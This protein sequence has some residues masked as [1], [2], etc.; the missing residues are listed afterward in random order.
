[1]NL[2]EAKAAHESGEYD[3]ALEIFVPM[4][5][6]GDAVAQACLG[7]MYRFG[8]GVEE[9]AAEA[10]KWFR[11]AAE[12]GHDMA[13]NS[14]GLMYLDGEGVKKN[15]AEGMQWLRRAAEQCQDWNALTFTQLRLA[16]MYR[17]GDG[18]QQDGAEAVKWLRKAAKLG[19]GCA[20]YDLGRMYLDGEGVKQDY[21]EAAKW[22]RK[23]AEGGYGDSH[24]QLGRLYL[25]GLGV[26]QD[27]AEAAKLFCKGAELGDPWCMKAFADFYKKGVYLREDEC[28][29]MKLYHKA[30]EEGD[31]ELQRYLGLREYGYRIYLNKLTIF[32]IGGL[33]TMVLLAWYDWIMIAN[34]L[35]ASVQKVGWLYLILAALIG[36][37]LGRWLSDVPYRVSTNARVTGIPFPVILWEPATF[38]SDEWINFEGLYTIVS[39]LLNA[40]YL[41]LVVVAILLTI[42]A[43]YIRPFHY[44]LLAIAGFKGFYDKHNK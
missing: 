19:Q 38:N 37:Y 34:H 29:L 42:P 6:G 15:I 18:V 11:K 16:E 24:Y 20:Q 8:M 25:E 5:E 26:R 32:T 4:A 9:D 14:L 13:Q 41:S 28:E 3:K 35:T 40:C 17:R 43:G 7:E 2:K 44:V 21:V 39:P 1:M 10:A 22:L 30:T 12:Q 27:D 33:L 31:A 36:L 23:A